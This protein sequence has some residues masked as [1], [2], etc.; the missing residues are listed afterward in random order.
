MSIST[1]TQTSG[2]VIRSARLQR[3]QRNAARLTLILPAIGALAAAVS[4]ARFGISSTAVGMLAFMYA[5]TI[6]GITVGYHRLFAHRAFRAGA[7]VRA[8]LAVMGSMAAQG[9]VIHWVANHRRHHVFSD[10]EGDPHSPH[11]PFRAGW[12]G[13]WHSHVGWM[14]TAAPSNPATFCKDLLH[15]KLI[16]RIN[17]GYPLWVL[18]G[19]LAPAAVA[20]LVERSLYAA[21]QGLLWGGFARVFLAHQVT[22]GINSITHLFGQRPFRTREF[23]TN[24]A[25]LALPS[26]GEA[27]HNN[28]HAFAQSARFG[29]LRWQI[30]LGWYV[31]CALH[32]VRLIDEVKTP[33]RAAIE[34]R[35]CSDATGASCRTTGEPHSVTVST[36]PAAHVELASAQTD[37]PRRGAAPPI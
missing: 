13:F 2:A 9:P 27:W 36:R 19:L 12:R 1:D 17:R 4:A 14:L 26:F 25:W 31:I 11:T 22:F 23:S 16:F 33:D 5:L 35:Q 24:N 29:L 20:G 10:A 15:D 6:T 32:A 21:L 37:A 7:A 28:H 30:D 8:V 34:Q 3:A 18:L